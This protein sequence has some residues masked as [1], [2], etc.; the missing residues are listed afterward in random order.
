M[1]KKIVPIYF[2]NMSAI[3]YKIPLLPASIEYLEQNF[4]SFDKFVKK[5]NLSK[6]ISLSIN[7]RKFQ[8]FKSYINKNSKK[9]NKYQGKMVDYKK[10]KQLEIKKDFYIADHLYEHF[11]CKILDKNEFYKLTKRNQ[12]ILKK[13]KNNLKFFSY[14]NGVFNKC[15]DKQNI[16]W[17]KNLK[18]K[19]TFGC[20]NASNLSKTDLFWKE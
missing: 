18:Y 3:K 20:S 16:N 7:T 6:P 8:K 5:N 9:I 19:K 15:F 10:L 12:T 17:L 14:P 13:F 1:K 2:L 4:Q 11:N